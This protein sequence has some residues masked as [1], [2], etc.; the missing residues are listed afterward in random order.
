MRSIVNDPKRALLVVTFG[1]DRHREDENGHQTQPQQ[2]PD[3]RADHITFR[4]LHH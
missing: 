3:R 1:R 2:K 4:Q